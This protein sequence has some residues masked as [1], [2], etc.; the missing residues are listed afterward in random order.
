MLTSSESQNLLQDD[1]LM[2]CLTENNYTMVWLDPPSLQ[3]RVHDGDSVQLRY[4]YIYIYIYI[5]NIYICNIYIYIYICICVCMCA[6]GM[7]FMMGADLNDTHVSY[8]YNIYIIYICMYYIYM[9]IYIYYTIYI[10]ITF[11]I[12]CGI[13]F[14]ELLSIKLSEFPTAST[15]I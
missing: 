11:I 12:S 5:C 13:C 4:L 6:L 14:K 10:Y 2:S 1:D 9:Y 8:I 7:K 15:F 3:D